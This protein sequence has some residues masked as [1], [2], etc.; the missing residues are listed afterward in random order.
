[1]KSI[2]TVVLGSLMMVSAAHADIAGKAPAFTL[3]D[4]KGKRVKV[5]YADKASKGKVTFLVFFAT[6]CPHCQKELPYVQKLADKYA[7]NSKVRILGVRTFQAR[8][9]EPIADFI[10][11]FGVK[12]P[13][14]NDDAE[15]S[16][17][18]DL[19]QVQGVPTTFLIDKSGEIVAGPSVEGFDGYVQEW[20]KAI[21]GLLKKK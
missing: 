9:R 4:Q 21:D 2:L 19:Y 8:E 7:K 6:W 13:I 1:M 20:S 5:D 11:R 10:K 15:S 18:A 12:F 14:L 16:A 17:T 3:K